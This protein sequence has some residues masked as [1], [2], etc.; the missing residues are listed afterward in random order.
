VTAQYFGVEILS[1][2][3]ELRI[4]APFEGWFPEFPAVFDAA[5]F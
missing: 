4:N 1:I 5:R 3:A 2:L